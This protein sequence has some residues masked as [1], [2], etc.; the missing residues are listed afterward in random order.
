MF[1]HSDKPCSAVMIDNKIHFSFFASFGIL[2]TQVTMK[3][4]TMNKSSA[5]YPPFLT[6]L[7]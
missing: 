5:S 2:K 4:R 7:L 6:S 3:T 1:I